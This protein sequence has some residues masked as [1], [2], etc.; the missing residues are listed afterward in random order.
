MRVECLS[1]HGTYDTVQRDGTRYFHQCPPLSPAELR[2]A[3][4]AHTVQLSDV[5]Q[6]RIAAA[7][8]YDGRNPAKDGQPTQAEIVFASIVVERPNARNENVLGGREPKT[9]AEIK[10]AGAGVQP[11][12]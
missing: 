6:A 4:A 9:A 11:I 10:A 2:D 1:C 7:Q 8:A 5:D 12:G 3:I